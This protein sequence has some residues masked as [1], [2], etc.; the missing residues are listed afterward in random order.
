M[1]CEF[2]FLSLVRLLL[3]NLTFGGND[4]RRSGMVERVDHSLRRRELER[5][6]V[7]VQRQYLRLAAA[8]RDRFIHDG[9]IPGAIVMPSITNWSAEERPSITNTCSS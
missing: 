9:A 7:H 6:K 3:S 1:R 5:Q 8:H 2:S 4:C